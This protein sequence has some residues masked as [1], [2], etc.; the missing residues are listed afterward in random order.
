[1]NVRETVYPSARRNVVGVKYSSQYLPAAD[2]QGFNEISSIS[3]N[4][5]RG[6]ARVS[7]SPKAIVVQKVEINVKVGT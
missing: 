5:D 1:M 2:E 6:W 3:Q 4:L 7:S